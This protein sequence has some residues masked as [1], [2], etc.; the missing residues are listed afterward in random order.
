MKALKV[1]KELIKL[2]ERNIKEKEEEKSL[3]LRP[4]LFKLQKQMSTVP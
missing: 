3:Y 1:G 4:L 2:K